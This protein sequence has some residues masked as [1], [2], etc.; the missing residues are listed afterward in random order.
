MDLQYD[1]WVRWDGEI[2][3]PG[4]VGCG[5]SGAERGAESGGVEFVGPEQVDDAGVSVD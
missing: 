1:F 5:S 2:A 4:E 3:G